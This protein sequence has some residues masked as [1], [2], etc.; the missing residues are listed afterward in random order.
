MFNT[1]VEDLAKSF[2]TLN[3][4][5]YDANKDL[6]SAKCE[7]AQVELDLIVVEYNVTMATDFK[8]LGITNKE[9]RTL[10]IQNSPE[11][12]ELSKKK[13][14][15]E[16]EI[17]DIKSQIEYKSNIMKLINRIIDYKTMDL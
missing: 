6:D 4:E 9:G 11:I 5:L 13:A 12:M 15:I 14:Q 7:L 16:G 2:E 10:Y 8:G 3:E 1:N 17:S